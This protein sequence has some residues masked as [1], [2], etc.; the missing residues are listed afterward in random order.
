M[1]NDRP[2]R[3]LCLLVPALLGAGCGAGAQGRP[4]EVWHTEALRPGAIEPSTPGE[5]ALLSRLSDLPTGEPIT[6]EGETFVPGA[7]YRAASGRSCRP[8][9]RASGEARAQRRLGCDGSAGWTFV[10]EISSE[11]R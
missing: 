4:D 8:I 1:P 3:V 7:P 10:P 5:R 2:S 11:S 9:E 6:L